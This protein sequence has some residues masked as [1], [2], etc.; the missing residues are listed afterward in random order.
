MVATHFRAPI[1]ATAFEECATFAIAG[2]PDLRAGMGPG[3]LD[4]SSR[5]RASDERECGKC[6]DV[7]P[8]GCVMSQSL[9]RAADCYDCDPVREA[10]RQRASIR[11]YH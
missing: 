2:G 6:D 4:L 10:M 1:K 5:G 9:P 3:D 7:V 8:I 11:E